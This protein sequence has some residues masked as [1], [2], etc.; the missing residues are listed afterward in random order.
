MDPVTLIGLIASVTNLIHASRVTL[1][2]I[3]TFKDGDKNL[4]ELSNDITVFAEALAG[5]ERVLRSRATVHRISGPAIE[6]VVEVSTNTIKDLR[7]RLQQI[8]SSDI[9]AVRRAKWVQNV[10]KIERLH[11]RLR[12]QN[13]M[14]QTFLSIT[15]A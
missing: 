9:S 4:A 2:V 15:H 13:A 14:L 10:S 5:F 3:R 8:S 1:D 7:L 12:E 6:S 11:E